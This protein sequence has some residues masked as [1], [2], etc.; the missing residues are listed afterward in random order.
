MSSRSFA[1]PP[2]FPPNTDKAVL[3]ARARAV[4]RALK[5]ETPDAAARAAALAPLARLVPQR[6]WVAA[7]YHPLGA[8]LDPGPLAVRLAEAGAAIAAPVVVE[9][10][11]P[12]VFRLQTDDERGVD[13][14]GI[15]VPAADAPEV[16]P[17]L[18]IVPLLAFDRS[19]ARLGQG[20]GST[21]APLRSY[22]TGERCWRWAWPMPA[23]RS[24][25]CPPTLS[26]NVWMAF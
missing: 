16:T 22:A 8:E 21:T 4:R 11:A 7:I 25:A 9:R 12:L 23:R 10:D 3:R 26:I 19:G 20:G 13:A 14:L 15:A 5:A 1:A 18:V 24:N 17:D 2:P 6:A